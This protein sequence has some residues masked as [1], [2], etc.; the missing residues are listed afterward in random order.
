MNEY[1]EMKFVDR[2][3]GAGGLVHTSYTCEPTVA[4]RVADERCEKV[5]EMPEDGTVDGKKLDELEPDVKRRVRER[6]EAIDARH[7]SVKLA[8]NY[9][10]RFK[11]L[12]GGDQTGS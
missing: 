9:L 12:W 4:T 1:Q 6:R 5:G 10:T 11:R 2:H 7:S 3:V 8:A